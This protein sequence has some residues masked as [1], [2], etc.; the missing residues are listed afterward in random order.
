[1]ATKY[2]KFEGE[3]RWAKGLFEEDNEYGKPNYNV[4]FAPVDA[5]KLKDAGIGL[6]PDKD[7][8]K[9]YRFRRY[10]EKT[11]PSGETTKFGPPKIKNKDGTPYE[12]TKYSIGNGSTVELNVAV[13]PAGKFKGHRLEEV[14]VLDLIE[15]VPE[16][17]T[18]G[19]AKAAETEP[20]T[21]AEVSKTAT[22]KPKLPF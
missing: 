5:S 12:G 13:F 4:L 14:R 17:R 15:F 20:S 11:W 1:M 6:R 18:E 2:Y 16:S 3:V 22:K 19:V 7:E 21:E 10:S 9:W 8:G